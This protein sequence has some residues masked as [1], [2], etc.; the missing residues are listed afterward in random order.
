MGSLHC[1]A[2]GVSN[3]CDNG[4]GYWNDTAILIVWDDWGGW[5]DHEPPSL[6]Q[7]PQKDY[8]YGF[9]VPLL[10]VSAYTP[11]GYIDNNRYDFGSIVRF[12]EQN[13]GL[14][15]GVLGFADARSQTD[16]TAF[17]S[18]ADRPRA[19]KSIYSPKDATYFI[20]DK[21]PPRNPDED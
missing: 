2:V 8:E 18:S 16:L 14:T 5:Y 9:R 15:E 7:Q 3:N 6:Q 11:P 4:Q 13:F 20:N 1:D 17:L 10:V 21:T 12:I 19:F